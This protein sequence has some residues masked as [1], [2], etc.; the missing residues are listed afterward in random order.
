MLSNIKKNIAQILLISLCIIS[1]AIPLYTHTA[2]AADKGI[3][4]SAVGLINEH[5][6]QRLPLAKGKKS[7]NALS[8]TQRAT[9]VIKSRW[10]SALAYGAILGASYTALFYA[11]ENERNFLNSFCTGFCMG[12]ALSATGLLAIAICCNN[13]IIDQDELYSSAE[14]LKNDVKSLEHELGVF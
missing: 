12:T 14:K 5:D 1:M 2:R 3:D 4:K 9:Y 11:K 7:L 8:L 10:K 13:L 6:Q